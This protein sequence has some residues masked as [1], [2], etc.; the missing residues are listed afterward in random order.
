VNKIDCSARVI[1]IVLVDLVARVLSSLPRRFAVMS[2]GASDGG[3]KNSMMP[4]H[5]ADDA[6]S[7]RP[8]QTSRPCGGTQA[9][10]NHQGEKAGL[11][12]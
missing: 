8:G 4:G 12:H 2:D 5:M 10:T 9:T 6:A 11:K 3:A 1:L 7:S